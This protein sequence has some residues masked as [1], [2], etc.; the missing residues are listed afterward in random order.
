M[1]KWFLFHHGQVKGPFFSSQV[2]SLPEAPESLIWGRGLNEWVNYTRWLG[3]QDKQEAAIETTKLRLQ[4]QWR[5]RIINQEYGPMPY[6]DLLDLLKGRTNYDRV[7]IWTEGYKEWQSIFGFHKLMDDLGVGRR[8]Y[9]RVPVS[10][11]VELKSLKGNFSGR[12]VSI[13]EGGMG[14]AEV[15]GLSVGDSVHVTLKNTNFIQPI[16]ASAEVVYIENDTFAGLKFNQVS[17]ETKNM[18]IEYVKHYL[19]QNQTP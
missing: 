17:S 15:S 14:V 11:Q 10:G 8:A 6:S 16:T 18:I 9:P 7:W 1:T 4:R 12:A 2:Q 19:N 13:S 5:A 3:W